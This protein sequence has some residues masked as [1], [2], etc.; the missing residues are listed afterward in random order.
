[1]RSAA[2]QLKAKGNEYFKKEKIG[3]A[4]DAYT[5]V[6]GALFIAKWCERG[7]WLQLAGG[8][9]LLEATSCNMPVS[10][11]RSL[12][13][14][15]I[16]ILAFE[17]IHL[18]RCFYLLCSECTVNRWRRLSHFAQPFPLTGPTGLFVSRRESEWPVHVVPE[19]NVPQSLA[20]VLEVLALRCRDN[21][22]AH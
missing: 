1:M 7:A 11:R 15:C 9:W 12:F 13:V 8:G 14:G 5:E 10:S 2:E 21:S 19:A 16:R 17:C 6:R 18:T 20:A 3:A 4:I 22:P